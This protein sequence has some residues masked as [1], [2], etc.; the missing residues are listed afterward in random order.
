MSADLQIVLCTVP[1]RETAE[2][3]AD[4]LVSE[5]LAAC[6]NILPGVTSVYR[7]QGAVEHSEELLLIIKTRKTAWPVLE[8]RIQALHPYELPEIVAVPI[9]TG[10]AEYIQWLKNSIP[11]S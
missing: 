8:A 10:E 4:A 6:I 2:M 7:W 9:T 3:I 5:Q 1:K 11:A